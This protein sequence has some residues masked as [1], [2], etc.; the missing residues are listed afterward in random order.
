MK[1]FDFIPKEGITLKEL[2]KKT[3]IKKHRLKVNLKNLK[4]ENLIT[5]KN[6]KYYKK[7]KKK[8]N[9]PKNK[10]FNTLTG[11]VYLIIL[12]IVSLTFSIIT[13]MEWFNKDCTSTTI[14][15]LETHYTF[16]KMFGNQLL[17]YKKINPIDFQ[18][19]APSNFAY[20]YSFVVYLI[21]YIL[22]PLT[23]NLR[24]SFILT[25]LI[26]YALSSISLYLLLKNLTKNNFSSFF[27]SFL[28]LI[29]PTL[30][31]QFSIFGSYHTLV[32][33]NFLLL[34]LNF[35]TSYE[36]KPSKKNLILLL[37]FSFL[38]A[39]THIFTFAIYLLILATYLILKKD[40]KLTSYLILLLIC[41]S[42]YYIPL[43]Y[44]KFFVSGFSQSSE[45][46]GIIG[47]INSFF[48]FV[49]STY[50]WLSDFNYGPFIFMLALI[51]TFLVFFSFNKKKILIKKNINK[52]VIVLVITQ[53]ILF[54]IFSYLPLFRD[55]VPNERIGFYLQVLFYLIIGYV[56]SKLELNLFIPLL[57]ILIG[58]VLTPN[59]ELYI[60][61]LTP[62]LIITLICLIISKKYY[63]KLKHLPSLFFISLLLLPS[64]NLF[65]ETNVIPRVW[66]YSFPESASNLMNSSSV[67]FTN[68][69]GHST[70][71]N[72]YGSRMGK[73]MGSA[74]SSSLN[75]DYR[76]E[77][78]SVLENLKL[79][80]IT[81]IVTLNDYEHLKLWFND[82]DEI[83]VKRRGFNSKFTYYH[84]NFKNLHENIQVES[85]THLIVNTSNMQFIPI[86]YH[87]FWESNSEIFNQQ[88]YIGFN[89]T[90]E[91]IELKFNTTLFKISNIITLISIFFLLSLLKKK[92]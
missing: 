14:G 16:Y 3:G 12:I 75:L 87:P 51:S 65:N 50:T 23:F 18:I 58:G 62:L 8:F 83:L 92:E 68:M 41:T 64:T 2:R 66:C 54:L 53:I 20:R 40:I 36:K 43:V 5:Y 7:S 76:T 17:N 61:S 55:S 70:L 79:A 27:I 63:L 10:I 9:F 34:S 32:S 46:P 57:L 42:Y 80:G 38:C 56:F 33:L 15:D 22:Y 74:G 52:I 1:L 45:N 44:D 84:T 13:G 39:I 31:V 29:S 89:S 35:L 21:P 67:Y 60:S 26:F 59:K 81:E 78:D 73:G 86:Y 77:N 25:H 69:E 19:S 47:T 82:Y 24:N 85:P 4:N 71:A 90:E 6:K 11:N 30:N 28:F 48:S 91:I 37:V 72:F 49:P 88:G